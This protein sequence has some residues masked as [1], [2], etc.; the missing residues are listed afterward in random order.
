MN[1]RTA[2]KADLQAIQLILKELELPFEDCDV[3]IDSFIVAEHADEIIGIGG[4]ERYGDV[5]LLRS[6]AVVKAR[7]GEGLGDVLY[8]EVKSR[9]ESLNVK[10]LYLLTETAEHYFKARG[11]DV[12]SRKAVPAAIEQT[13]QFSSLC[14]ASATVMKKTL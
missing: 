5:A 12:I 9:A 1:I 11:F 13:Q 10:E 14:P 6:I 7:R 4:M 2:N 8:S 3:H